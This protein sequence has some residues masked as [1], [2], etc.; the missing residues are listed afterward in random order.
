[1]NGA[2]R[3]RSR[4]PLVV[5]VP[6]LVAPSDTTQARECLA[7]KRVCA[8]GSGG[9]EMH[10]GKRQCSWGLPPDKMGSPRAAERGTGSFLGVRWSRKK[11]KWRVRIKANGKVMHVA[12]LAESPVARALERPNAQLVVLLE[13]PHN[14]LRSHSRFCLTTQDNHVGF[15]SDQVAAAMAYDAALRRYN[16]NSPYLKFNFPGAAHGSAGSQL[17]ASVGARAAATAAGF[18][19]RMP[20]VT[21]DAPGPAAL[22]GQPALS[23]L[24]VPCSSSLQV[25]MG[26][27]MLSGGR[28]HM[29]SPWHAA[30]GAPRLAPLMPSALEAA[31][32]RT[33][34]PPMEREAEEEGGTGGLAHGGCEGRD[35]GGEVRK[36]AAAQ[37]GQDSK[38]ALA[39]L[40][41]QSGPSDAVCL[42][43]LPQ[44]PNEG[45]VRRPGGKGGSGRRGGGSGSCTSTSGEMAGR[46]ET[47]GREPHGRETHGLA[48]PDM[49]KV[50]KKAAL[51]HLLDDTSSLARTPSP[52]DTAPASSA[53][54]VNRRS[55]S[56]IS[57]P[58]TLPSPS[59]ILSPAPLEEAS[60]TPPGIA[61]P[62]LLTS[63]TV[64]RKPGV[65]APPGIP[66]C[67][68]GRG[69]AGRAAGHLAAAHTG[70]QP[71]TLSGIHP[72][73]LA[74]TRAGAHTR[75]GPV[76][77]EGGKWGVGERGGV[78]WGGG[79]GGGGG[80]G[81]GGG[82]HLG[83]GSEAFTGEQAVEALLGLKHSKRAGHA[84]RGD[85]EKRLLAWQEVMSAHAGHKDAVKDE[86]VD[87]ARTEKADKVAR[88]R[89]LASRSREKEKEKEKGKSGAGKK[90][91]GYRGVT[92]DR[93]K[94]M[95][96][97]RLCH[98]GGSREHV[99][100][101][102]NEQE[103]ARY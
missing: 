45:L 13:P 42:K 22:L 56:S 97:V 64:V 61:G 92:W 50:K 95:W 65:I 16:P 86:Q 35:G 68:H 5:S 38:A 27:V 100:Y 98:P 77:K 25:S 94:Q 51:V 11:N 55:I 79:G 19:A 37:V 41:D 20:L 60:H 23:L 47:H 12:T 9:A 48:A 90:G 7:G 99:G 57:T 102:S 70:D 26:G 58:A 31:A 3:P 21:V 78:G 76:E 87:A 4:T 28:L 85:G 6:L 89:Q 103:G 15:Y 59:V 30:S 24:S 2:A 67:H 82:L 84:P 1:M 46:G 71:H 44:P 14:G 69:R 34:H 96:R 40:L 53:S 29:A 88:H 54:A 32:M 91:Q 18:P 8:D 80:D 33:N 75:P 83:A 72:P 10:S 49:D 93:V 63:A 52:A 66:A 81:G 43:D 101:F 17:A 73:I 36:A 62:P 74:E 39:H